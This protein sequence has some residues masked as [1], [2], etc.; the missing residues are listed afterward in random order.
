VQLKPCEK[1]EKN[2]TNTSSEQ[3]LSCIEQCI[4]KNIINNVVYLIILV[5]QSY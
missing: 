3:I 5:S 4:T 1:P 2:L